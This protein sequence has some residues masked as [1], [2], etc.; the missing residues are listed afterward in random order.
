MVLDKNPSFSGDRVN[1]DT[2]LRVA[3]TLWKG[4]GGDLNRIPDSYLEG[5]GFEYSDGKVSLLNLLNKV[6]L[7]EGTYEEFSEVV[8]KLSH[9]EPES[10]PNLESI[11]EIQAEKLLSVTDEQLSFSED[12]ANFAESEK[13]MSDKME[14]FLKKV[15]SSVYTDGVTS[16]TDLTGNPPN[17]ANRYLKGEDGGSFSGIFYDSQGEDGGKSFKF[18][19]SKKKDGNWQIVY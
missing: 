3:D 11:L 19:I 5:L 7:S 18:E 1:R 8:R 14:L 16:V 12:F 4:S 13:D 10:W 9:T 2:S 6:S 15:I 17:K